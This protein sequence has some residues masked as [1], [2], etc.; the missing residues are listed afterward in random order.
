MKIAEIRHMNEIEANL[1]LNESEYLGSITT[2]ESNQ[3]AIHT[4]IREIVEQQQNIFETF[5]N[6]SIHAEKRIKEIE[7]GTV[8]Y[9]TRV[10]ENAQEIIKEISRLTASSNEVCTC[11]TGD[12]MQYIYNHFFDIKK[13]LLDRQK[14]GEHRGIRYLS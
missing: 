14:K 5:W 12:G 9:E 10:I 8:H 1:L 11:L 6:R 7:E 3:Q 2:S 4:N 13:K